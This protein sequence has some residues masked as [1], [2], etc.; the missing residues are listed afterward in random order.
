MAHGDGSNTLSGEAYGYMMTEESPENDNIDDD[1]YDKYIGT[2]VIMDVW[3]EGLR[4]ATV[5]HCIEDLDGAKV[6][7]YYRKPLIDP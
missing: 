2:E 5:R 3:G 6:G 1:A 7:I 4:R